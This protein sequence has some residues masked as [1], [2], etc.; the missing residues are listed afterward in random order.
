MTLLLI[1]FKFKIKLFLGQSNI[2]KLRG[3]KTNAFLV[4]E[5]N[6]YKNS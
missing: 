6:Q 1:K 2:F 4:Y 3:H 5:H